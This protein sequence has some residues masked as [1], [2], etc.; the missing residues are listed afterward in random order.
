MKHI[1]CKRT[2]GRLL[3]CVAP[4]FFKLLNTLTETTREKV[5]YT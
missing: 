4:A 2:A 1:V 5:L 3:L